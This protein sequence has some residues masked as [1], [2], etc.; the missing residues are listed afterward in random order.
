[1][2]LGLENAEFAADMTIKSCSAIRNQFRHT[3]LEFW[4]KSSIDIEGYA[5]LF[6]EVEPTKEQCKILAE[7]IANQHVDKLKFELLTQ[8]IAVK[9]IFSVQLLTSCSASSVRS[10]MFTM[11]SLHSRL[12]SPSDTG[13]VMEILQ[14]QYVL[15]ESYHAKAP[16]GKWTLFASRLSFQE[17][18]RFLFKLVWLALRGAFFYT[19]FHYVKLANAPTD[20]LALWATIFKVIE[21]WIPPAYM[22]LTITILG[23]GSL[24]MDARGLYFSDFFV[25]KCQRWLQGRKAMTMELMMTRLKPYLPE[26]PILQWICTTVFATVTFVRVLPW[27]DSFLFRIVPK[28]VRNVCLQMFDC[29]MPGPSARNLLAQDVKRRIA[30]TRKAQN[31]LR[32]RGRNNQST[33]NIRNAVYDVVEDANKV[34]HRPKRRRVALKNLTTEI[35]RSLAANNH[36]ASSSK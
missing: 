17:F 10:L 24:K 36:S 8:Q 30:N 6:T 5:G 18:I 3:I 7:K 14:A 32:K 2:V 16:V 13:N 1:M 31:M 11:E 28:A 27:L 26:N 25:T 9:L 35:H 15:L 33:T 34:R 22:D 4:G 19:F 21:S 29:V 12:L 20:M 23:L